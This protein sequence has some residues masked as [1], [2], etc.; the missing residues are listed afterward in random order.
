MF[1][2]CFTT[3]FT[4]NGKVGVVLTRPL[5]GH[6]APKGAAVVLKDPRLKI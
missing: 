2:Y 3:Y 1:I 4:T 6:Q 5:K